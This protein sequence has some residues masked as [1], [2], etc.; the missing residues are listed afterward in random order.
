M[1]ISCWKGR[2]AICIIPSRGL[3]NLHQVFVRDLGL[4]GDASGSATMRDWRMLLDWP[5]VRR[6]FIAV[7]ALP[8]I[9]A[10]EVLSR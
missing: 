7:V 5:D 2:Q 3:I 9:E 4:G 10:P 8:E 6:I 1:A